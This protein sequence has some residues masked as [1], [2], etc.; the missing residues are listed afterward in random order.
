[1]KIVILHGTGDNPDK[2]WFP[3]L[4]DVLEERGH[5]VFIPEFPTPANQ[6]LENWL[7][8]LK[9]QIHFTFDKDTIL[10][11]H[12]L[13]ANFIL[14]LLER[15]I[16][17]PVRKAIL[18][19]G[20]CNKLGHKVYDDLNKTFIDKELNWEKIKSNAI[21]FIIYHGE[22]DPYVP[23]FEAEELEENLDAELNI[24]PDGKHLDEDAGLVMFEELLDRIEEDL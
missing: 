23:I 22:D 10:I 13:G 5:E 3:W 4:Q 15:D 14:H 8:A 2:N 7:N 12:N 18:V 6:S 9:D 1:M 20:F 19:S 11:G 16:K 24:I 21:E 17:E